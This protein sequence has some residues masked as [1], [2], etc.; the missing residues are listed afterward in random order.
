MS[1]AQDLVSYESKVSGH[2]QLLAVTKTLAL[3]AGN[4][5]EHRVQE[6][7][8]L[9]Q[10]IGMKNV[11]KIMGNR[12][13]DVW[14]ALDGQSGFCLDTAVHGQAGPANTVVGGKRKRL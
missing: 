11:E 6:I 9:F 2:S 13:G 14:K 5:W 7:K 8:G 3:L 4:R 10:I 12:Y 1:G